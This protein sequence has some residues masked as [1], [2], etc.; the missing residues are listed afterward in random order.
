MSIEERIIRF[1]MNNVGRDF[2]VGDIH[3][4]FTELRKAL[5]AAGFNP[6]CDRLFSVGDLV[7]RGPESADVDEWLQQPWFHA[8]RGNHEQMTIDTYRINNQDTKGHHFINGGAWFTSISRLEQACYAVALETLPIA[9]EVET[10]EGLVGL[11]HAD[12]P[13]QTW[14]AMRAD[15]EKP[16]SAANAWPLAIGV[17]GACLWSRDR[18][19]GENAAGVPDIRAVVV[20]HTPLRQVAVLGNVFHIDTRG[21]QPQNGGY[22]TLLD[23]HTLEAIPPIPRK[24]QW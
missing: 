24:L 17:E 9:I 13:T 6:A 5:D 14:A 15:L 3:G 2:A 19:Q 20:G 23:L 8:V 22:F 1:A 4:H 16:R 12:C 21:W 10:P 7:D 18:I 11:V